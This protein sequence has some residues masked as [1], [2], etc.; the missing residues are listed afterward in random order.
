MSWTWTPELL[1]ELARFLGERGITDG[2]VTTTPIGDGHSNLTFLVS[3]G[4]RNA[5]LRRP[6]P[7]PVPPGAHDMLREARLIGALG[8]TDVPVAQLLAVAEAGELLDVPCY[9]MSHVSGPVVTTETPAPLDNPTDRAAVA[10][11]LVRTL[12]ALHAVD[13]AAVGLADLGRDGNFNARHLRSVGRLVNDENG[14][15]PAEFAPI[16]AWLKARVPEQSGVSVVHNDY[17]IGN[18]ILAPDAPGQLAAVLDWELATIGDPLFDLGYFLSSW[19]EPGE[20]LTPTNKFGA[21]A[22]EDGYPRRDAL[23]ERYAELTGRDLAG[24]DW[25]IALAQWKVACL[26]EY[27]RRRV[28]RGGGDEYYRDREQV[29]SFLRAAHRVAGIDEPVSVG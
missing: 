4:T 27:G 16:D 7:P 26:Y 22:F 17:R 12:A 6:P 13:V 25:Y 14:T 1:G 23:A 8:T 9:V 20:E 5:V 21:A 24:I 28:E 3:D 11:S 19:P 10:E 18:V 2:P 29:L 15:P